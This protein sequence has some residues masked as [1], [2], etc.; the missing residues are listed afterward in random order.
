MNYWLDLFTVK[1]LDDF[2]KAG[3]SV[4]GFRERRFKT[5]QQ[6]QP[7][8]KLL[9]YVTGISRWVGVLRV[10]KPAYR[11]NERIWD[12][13][14]FPVRLGVE[15]EILLP[16]EHGIPHQTLQPSLHSPV[17]SWG[18]Y[19]RG[20]PTRLQKEDAEVILDAVQR[21]QRTPVLRP[22]DKKKADR[23]PAANKATGNGEAKVTTGER[24]GLCPW[25]PTFS[26]LRGYLKAI[27]GVVVS[28]LESLETAI[29][30]LRGTPQ[31]PVS[32]ES[33][34]VWIGDR[35]Q[36]SDQSLAERFWSLSGNRVNPRY[37]RGPGIVADRY[38]LIEEIERTWAIT[39]A[40]QDLLSAEFGATERGIDLQEGMGELLKLLQVKPNARRGDLLPGWR[41]FVVG[42]STFGRSRSS[43]TSS[44]TGSRASWTAS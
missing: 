12:L 30:G 2:H 33:P 8:D 10:T 3:A 43:S 21:A 42:H 16:P 17:R 44:T 1:T 38:G 34:E 36:G 35:L 19:L 26:Q 6:I 41:D 23:V 24:P 15:A 4:S 32:W 25:L 7:G 14:V 20:S 27:E 11:S 9:C 39:A 40:G 28:N 13:E 18:G 31:E 5:C 22:Y 37:L 29:L